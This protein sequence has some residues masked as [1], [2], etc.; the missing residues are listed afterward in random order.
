MLMKNVKF[1][2]ILKYLCDSVKL[3][4]TFLNTNETTF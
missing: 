3:E 4:N 1:I 2:S